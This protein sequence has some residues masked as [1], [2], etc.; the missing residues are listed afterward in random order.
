MSEDHAANHGLTATSTDLKLTT[1]SSIKMVD[2][3]NPDRVFRARAL[4]FLNAMLRER[5]KEQELLCKKWPQ[6]SKTAILSDGIES[7]G[8]MLADLKILQYALCPN[9]EH[10]NEKLRKRTL[11]DELDFVV[12]Q[13]DWLQTTGTDCNIVVT[14]IQFIQ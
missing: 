12:Q 11:I 1:L 4:M 14:D 9:P 2:C 3:Y 10:S 7:D 5:V 8:G 6:Y 13:V